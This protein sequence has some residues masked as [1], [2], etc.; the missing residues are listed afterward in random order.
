MGRAGEAIDMLLRSSSE[1]SNPATAHTSAPNFSPGNALSSTPQIENL[2]TLELLYHLNQTEGVQL[3][4]D[5]ARAFATFDTSQGI[6]NI[7]SKAPDCINIVSHHTVSLLAA[8]KCAQNQGASFN[9]CGDNVIC[10]L[11]DVTVQGASYGEAALRALLKY[12]LTHC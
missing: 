11:K 1:K 10:V 4:G 3:V 12:Q 2:S 8:L 7:Y 5:P 6:L 9:V